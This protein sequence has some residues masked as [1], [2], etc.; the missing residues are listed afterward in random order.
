MRKSGTISVIVP[1]YKVEKYI[2]ECIESLTGQTY[3]DLEIIL[4]DDGS[5]DLC[6]AICDRYAQTDSRIIV[7]HLKNGGAAAA[8]NA[9]LRVAT[10]AYIAFVDGDDYLEPDACEH[11]VQAMEATGAD[12]VQGGLR[13]N[14]ANGKNVRHPASEPRTLSTT[15]YLARFTEDWTCAIACDKL[16]RHHVLEGVFYEEGHLIDDEFFTYRG[17]MNARKIAY[18]PDITYNYRQRASSV[19]KDAARWERKNLDILNAVEKRRKDVCARFPDLKAHF[20]NHYVDYLLYLAFTEQTT[21]NTIREIKKRL[22]AYTACGKVLPW[23]KGQR[24]LFLRTMTLL[25]QPADAIFRKR[26]EPTEY[27][28]YE[29]FE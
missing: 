16:F 18:I 2:A 25:A 12:V 4:A 3:R 11:L 21:V 10:G 5:P 1:I 27:G 24:K 28:E 20:E 6:G 17:I 8:R 15:E 7:L 9:A 19:M 14:Y 13:Y 26:K 29:F 23:R 22:L